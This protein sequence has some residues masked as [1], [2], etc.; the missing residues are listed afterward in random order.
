[1]SLKRQLLV[2]VAA[3]CVVPMHVQAA[4]TSAGSV[5][6]LKGDIKAQD[7]AGADRGLR[8]GDEVTNGESLIAGDESEAVVSMADGAVLAIRPNSRFKIENVKRPDENGAAFALSLIRGGLRIISGLTGKSDPKA[9]RVKTATA[10]IG[11]RGTDHEPFVLPAGTKIGRNPSGTYDK[12]NSGATVLQMG[13]EQTE[14][15]PGQVGF[16]RDPSQ[17]QDKTRAMATLLRPVILRYVPEFFKSGTFDDQLATM[18]DQVKANDG[19]ACDAGLLARKWLGSLDGGIGARRSEDVLNLFDVKAK[20]TV[21]G[22]QAPNGDKPSE[23]AISREEFVESVVQS[24]RDLESFSQTRHTI[25]ADAVTPSDACALIRVQSEVT[26][27]GRAAGKF[28]S[29]RTRETYQLRRV[30]SG[31]QAEAVEVQPLPDK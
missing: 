17:P 28:Y 13:D 30:G 29:A 9:Y 31:Y 18:A 22:A 16:A 15:Q 21:K 26:E 1:M 24:I 23:Y 19:S 5:W 2:T 11:I 4:P 8:L 14:L 7:E 6:M 27:S 3:V 25:Q 10:T 12:V 20:V